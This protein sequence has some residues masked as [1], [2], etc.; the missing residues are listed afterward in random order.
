MKTH[1]LESIEKQFHSVMTYQLDKLIQLKDDNQILDM[2]DQNEDVL[3]WQL[4]SVL[5]I[6]SAAWL[7]SKESGKKLKSWNFFKIF[8]K[9]PYSVMKDNLGEG[10]ELNQGKSKT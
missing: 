5:G 2:N 7:K 6:Q 8:N 9:N 3:P 4:G 1:I 10:K